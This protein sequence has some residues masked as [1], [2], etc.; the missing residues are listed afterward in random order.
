MIKADTFQELINKVN[1]QQLQK[2]KE[3]SNRYEA[4]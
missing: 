2:Q 3:D 4:Y 1:E